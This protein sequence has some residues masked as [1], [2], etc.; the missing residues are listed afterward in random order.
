MP[1]NVGWEIVM[2]REDL[3]EHMRRGET[4]AVRQH[5]PLDAHEKLDRLISDRRYEVD[6]K[7]Y[8]M[9]SCVRALLRADGML[10]CE[11]D[12]AAAELIAHLNRG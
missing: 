10:Q 5:L 12:R 11:S 2:S 4:D 8:L 3:L 9:F 1:T 6:G 7:A